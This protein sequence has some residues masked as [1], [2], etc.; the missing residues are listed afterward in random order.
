MDPRRATVA[1]LGPL[2]SHSHQAAL[3]HFEP[4]QH[5]FHSQTTFQDVFEMVQSSR[6]DYGLVPFENSTH[7]VVEGTLDLFAD[8]HGSYPNVTVSGESYFEVHHFLLGHASGTP[9]PPSP[10]NP[11]TA[12]SIPGNPSSTIPLSKPLT[13]LSHIRHV[14]SHPQALGQCKHFL[15]TF[16]RHAEQH[17][18]SSTS[19]AAQ[20]VARGPP[21]CAAISSQGAATALHLDILAED[22][23]DGED[24]TT[25]FFSLQHKDQQLDLES[26]TSKACTVTFSTLEE[27]FGS[28]SLGIIVVKDLPARFIELRRRLLSYSSHLANL[29]A[30]KLAELENPRAKWLVGWSRG[31][32]MLRDGVYDTQ[33][34]SFYVNCAFYKDPTLTGASGNY[35]DFPEY[36]APNIWPDESILPGFRSTFEE[37]CRLI[38]DTAVL[39]AR[40]C[41]RYAEHAIHGYRRGCLERIVRE[42]TT[43]KARL[44]HYF[45]SERSYASASGE[46]ADD[47]DRKSSGHDLGD[48]DDDDDDDDGVDDG[49]DTS[50]WC[51]PHLDHGCLTGLTS[52]MYV[53]ELAQSACIRAT[54]ADQAP[55]PLKELD[56]STLPRSA[57]YS[58]AGLYILSR[59]N[60]PVKVSI[61]PDHLAFQTG[62]ALQV[63]TRGRFKAV[64]HF[65]H[66][67]SD[68]TNSGRLA[69]L[70]ILLDSLAQIL[71]PTPR[72]V[73]D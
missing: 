64:P 28:E 58:K 57:G 39:V 61:P 62:E 60:S 12:T 6:I 4:D 5:E 14:Y 29:P 8:R 53:D 69:L 13:S 65:G 49:G 38:I 46:L 34:G 30:D 67:D 35:P 22:V 41:D 42:S 26:D 50:D 21:D 17:E 45:P 48:V 27:A 71:A 66:V 44:L 63:I 18:V 73:R 19:K 23:E 32:E 7:G 33:K 68:D 37:L 3:R 51:A 15:S 11:V 47:R 9:V 56:P 36:T 55:P 25:R 10:T 59:T 72:L 1:F 20:D 70:P 31:R 52:A 43:T 2:W 16:L 54:A 40:A 24:N